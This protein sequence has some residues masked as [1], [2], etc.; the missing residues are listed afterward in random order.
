ML[1]HLGEQRWGEMLLIGQSPKQ[2]RKIHGLDMEGIVYWRY[3]ERL[4]CSL[5]V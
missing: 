1:E 4:L 3:P 2:E 5:S